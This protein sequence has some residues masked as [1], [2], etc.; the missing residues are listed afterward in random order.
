MLQLYSTVLLAVIGANAIAV[1]LAV[2][3]AADWRRRNK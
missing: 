3:L 2:A 1:L